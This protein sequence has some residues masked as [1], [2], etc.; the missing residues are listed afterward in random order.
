MIIK[1]VDDGKGYVIPNSE[2]SDVSTGFGLAI[3][4]ERVKLLN[5]D[6]KCEHENGTINIISIPCTQITTEA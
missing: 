2:L 6:I 3:I 1:H 5:G 4:K